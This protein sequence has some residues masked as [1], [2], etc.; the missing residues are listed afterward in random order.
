M[1]AALEERTLVQDYLVA[2]VFTV[3]LPGQDWRVLGIA[4]QFFTLSQPRPQ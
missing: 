4:G 3:P 1:R 2:R